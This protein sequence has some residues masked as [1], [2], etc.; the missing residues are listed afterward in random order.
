MGQKWE[1]K[2]VNL[3][4]EGALVTADSGNLGHA[5][6]VLDPLKLNEL[7]ARMGEEGW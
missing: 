2:V 7:L 4:D 6:L 1:Y 5:P 3:W